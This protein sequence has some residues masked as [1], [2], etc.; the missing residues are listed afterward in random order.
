[1]HAQVLVSKHPA[2]VSQAVLVFLETMVKPVYNF[3]DPVQ[4]FFSQSEAGRQ[5]AR[6]SLARIASRQIDRDP[7][8]TEANYTRQGK[9]QSGIMRTRNGISNNCNLPMYR[10]SLFMAMGT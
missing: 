4:L 9:R 6:S 1:M 2:F 8:V 7:A 3:D 10:C 5:S